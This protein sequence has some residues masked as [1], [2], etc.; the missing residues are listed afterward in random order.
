LNLNCAEGRRNGQSGQAGIRD[1]TRDGRI[2]SSWL[3]GR[4]NVLPVCNRQTPSA[5]GCGFVHGFAAGFPA[6]FHAAGVEFRPGCA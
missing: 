1:A 5:K 4:E 6:R 2:V 3:S